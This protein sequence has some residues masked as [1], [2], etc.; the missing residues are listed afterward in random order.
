[1][2]IAVGKTLIPD[3]FGITQVITTVHYIRK[4]EL[5]V[6][7]YIAQ[8][9]ADMKRKLEKEASNIY[10]IHP[11]KSELILLYEVVDESGR[12]EWGGANVEQTMQWLT[13]APKNSRV[14]VSAWDSDEEDAHLVGQT[15]DITEIIQEARKVG[16]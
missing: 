5:Q 8:Q 7:N 1:V 14:L 11:K 3:T 16:L 4:G 15:I 12:A 9:V 6:S 13:L 10:T 2:A